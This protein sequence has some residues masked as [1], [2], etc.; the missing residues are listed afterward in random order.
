MRGRQVGGV[1]SKYRYIQ[2]I[3]EVF[4]SVHNV[5]YHVENGDKHVKLDGPVSLFEL[6]N[7]TSEFH[8]FYSL[9]K[10]MESNSEGK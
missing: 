9:L 8:W 10:Y 1:S 6:T 4:L 2:D 3:L 7:Y 5:Q